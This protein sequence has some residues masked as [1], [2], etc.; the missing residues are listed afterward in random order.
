MFTTANSLLSLP[1]RR[2]SFEAFTPTH[3]NHPG[4]Q[5]TVTTRSTN[6]PPTEPT[7][8]STTRVRLA[9]AA[10]LVAVVVAISSDGDADGDIVGIGVGDREGAKET[11][12]EIVGEGGGGDDGA[13]E[14]EGE[15]VG[16]CVVG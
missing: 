11:E 3:A 9:C 12:G 6:A 13:G 10:S 16:D 15:S 5:H 1:F 7:A 8:I 4:Q 2:L 14:K